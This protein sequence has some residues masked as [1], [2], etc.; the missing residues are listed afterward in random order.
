MDDVAKAR[1]EFL[2]AGGK[3]YGQLVALPIPE[4]G[5]V[6]LVYL[7]DPEGNL[8]ELQSWKRETK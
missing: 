3:E 6:T 2:S 8:I 7:A 1:D 4:A 5:T